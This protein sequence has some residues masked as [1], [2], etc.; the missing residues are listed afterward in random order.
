M[1]ARGWYTR[2]QQRL[3]HNPG[4]IVCGCPCLFPM[5]HL[6]HHHG[7]DDESYSYSSDDDYTGHG[8]GSDEDYGSRQPILQTPMVA[9]AAPSVMSIAVALANPIKA[10]LEAA[11]L[12]ELPPIETLTLHINQKVPLGVL[13]AQK[14][15]GAKLRLRNGNGFTATYSNSDHNSAES[16]ALGIFCITRV[17]LCAWGLILVCRQYRCFMRPCQG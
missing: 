17:L 15:G 6:G 13:L 14:D 16:R 3:E 9:A 2:A 1:W 4:S 7:S 11:G 8:Y 5:S 12:L 10:N